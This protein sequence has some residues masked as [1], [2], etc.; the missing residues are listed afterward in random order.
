MLCFPNILFIVFIMKRDDIL[1]NMCG[2]F[3]EAF[4]IILFCFATWHLFGRGKTVT[5]AFYFCESGLE[6]YPEN[7]LFTL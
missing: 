5:E 3:V 1:L 7:T 2:L 4:L 6:K